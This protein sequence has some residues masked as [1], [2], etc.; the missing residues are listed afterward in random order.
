[1]VFHS[2]YR[3]K[4]HDSARKLPVKQYHPS[5]KV[6]Q[7]V[8]T[9][10][11][12]VRVGHSFVRRAKVAFLG[13][14]FGRQLYED[15]TE[16][17]AVD[18]ASHYKVSARIAKIHTMGKNIKLMSDVLGIVRLIMDKQPHMI[19]I[20]AAANDLAK[21]RDGATQ[22]DVERI[23]LQAKALALMVPDTTTVVCMAVI[24]RSDEHNMRCTQ[25]RFEDFARI[26]NQKLLGYQRAALEGHRPTNIRYGK[27][28][29][30]W[31]PVLQD[32]SNQIT[33]TTAYST[34]GV[35]PTPAM[36]MSRHSRDVKRVLLDYNNIPSGI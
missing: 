25:Q 34:D 30:W 29:G 3:Q 12:V 8:R 20:E 19:M 31:A 1:M 7:K 9:R 28:Q 5:E 33:D 18:L 32:G 15:T 14:S 4:G 27:L 36:F 6:R 22:R 10:F 13:G 2:S 26:Y 21:L 17:E 11:T 24:P 35:H 23:A 16:A